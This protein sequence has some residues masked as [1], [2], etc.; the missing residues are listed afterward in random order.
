MN[1]YQ[2]RNTEGLFLNIES[3]N[4]F[5]TEVFWRASYFSSRKI[6]EQ[7]IEKA[8]VPGLS[9][10]P[11]TE[12]E[13]TEAVATET[14]NVSIQM[15]SLAARL[16][17]IAYS[18]PTM[19]GVNKSLKNFIVNTSVK[20]KSVNPQFKE[21]LAKKEDATYDVQGVYDEYINTLSKIE[22]WEMEEFNELV[23]AFK[24]D[25]SSTL[26]FA[27]KINKYANK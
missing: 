27:R 10:I 14:T 7:I 4:P 20:L 21:F 24:H 23:K 19:S 8:G 15:D 26:G 17:R 22:M 5:F 2:L 13:F 12:L 25:K 3:K 1:I 18:L 9:I 6:A 16:D 11:T